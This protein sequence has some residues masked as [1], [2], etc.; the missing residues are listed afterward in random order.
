MYLPVP[1]FTAVLPSPFTS[2]AN[3]NLG[4]TSLQ[5]GTSD[6]DENCR[7]GTNRPAPTP[8]ASIELLKCSKRIPGLIEKRPSVHESCA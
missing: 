7:A 1:T 3:P 5:S 2:H 8:V 4:D 6:R